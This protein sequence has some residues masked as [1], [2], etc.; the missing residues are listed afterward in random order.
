MFPLFALVDQRRYEEIERKGGDSLQI[1]IFDGSF[2]SRKGQYLMA[3]F[4]KQ[5][6]QFKADSTAGSRDD[7]VFVHFYICNSSYR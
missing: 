6:Y 2:I 3:V 7:D 5:F 4:G 1:Q